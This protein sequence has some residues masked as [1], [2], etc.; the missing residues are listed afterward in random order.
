MLLPN[1]AS[2]ITWKYSW[3]KAHDLFKWLLPENVSDNTAV[4]R[5]WGCGVGEVGKWFKKSF[6]PS[7]FDH[8]KI[9]HFNHLNLHSILPSSKEIEL[10]KTTCVIIGR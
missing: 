5:G 6:Q 7:K 9:K 1:Y 8:F 10:D 3:V 2:M 4:E